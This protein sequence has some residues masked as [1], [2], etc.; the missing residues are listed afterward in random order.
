[1]TVPDGG[2][3]LPTWWSW[4]SDWSGCLPCMQQFGT[5]CP[6][7]EVPP[8]LI[9]IACLVGGGTTTVTGNLRGNQAIA[10]ARQAQAAARMAQPAAE[11]PQSAA[12]RTVDFVDGS[13]SNGP[14]NG[15]GQYEITVEDVQRGKNFD[16]ETEA[17]DRACRELA[18]RG[19]RR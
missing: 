7:C 5:V 13:A 3:W 11:P 6:S 10:T 4:M 2:F 12:D 9:A 8:G 1:M 18:R 14:L 15:L 16:L 19:N 17:M